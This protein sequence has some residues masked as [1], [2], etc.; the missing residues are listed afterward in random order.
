MRFETAVYLS[1]K[2]LFKLKFKGFQA[3]H[4]IVGETIISQIRKFFLKFS[5][6]KILIFL[7]KKKNFL[8]LFPEIK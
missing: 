8:F 1:I 2:F 4:E 7:D 3:L 5:N 6:I